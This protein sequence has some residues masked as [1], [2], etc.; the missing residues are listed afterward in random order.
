MAFFRKVAAFRSGLTAVAIHGRSDAPAQDPA[1][2][3]GSSLK[4]F[5]KRNRHETGSFTG[6]SRLAHAALKGPVVLNFQRIPTTCSEELA[7]G[8]RHMVGSAQTV[9]PSNR[10]FS[11]K[12]W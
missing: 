3:A 12:S 9:N 6:P 7:A 5:E 2:L 11:G 4:P 10:K 8:G 1:D